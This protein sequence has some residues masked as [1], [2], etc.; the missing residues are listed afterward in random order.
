M[1]EKLTIIDSKCIGKQNTLLI[2]M[3]WMIWTMLHFVRSVYLDIW[4]V[5]WY[6]CFWSLWFCKPNISST[7]VTFFSVLSCFSL[8]VSCFWLVLLVSQIF[9]SVSERFF[10]N[11]LIFGEDI[12]NDEVGRFLDTVYLYEGHSISSRTTSLIQ[13]Q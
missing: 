6:V 7:V 13:R 4:C 9:V 3:Q 8:L 11:L 12:E 5:E 10:K 1:H 2:K